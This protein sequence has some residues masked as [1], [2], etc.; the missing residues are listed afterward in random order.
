MLRFA[1]KY[2]L[3]KGKP[4]LFKTS[5]EKT[6]RFWLDMDGEF[7]VADLE[8]NKLLYTQEDLKASIELRPLNI[9][10]PYSG[11]NEV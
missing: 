4:A 8:T 9:P 6:A 3:A 7:I 5:N 10:V 2:K 11:E 1:I